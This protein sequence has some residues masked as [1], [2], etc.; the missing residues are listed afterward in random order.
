MTA[1]VWHKRPNEISPSEF[2][3][4]IMTPVTTCA[5]NQLQKNHATAQTGKHIWDALN[6]Q[7][8]VRNPPKDGGVYLCGLCHENFRHPPM[9]IPVRI[10]RDKD[11]APD[12]HYVVET[13]LPSNTDGYCCFECT[14]AAI[15]DLQSSTVEFVV[16]EAER[17][18]FALY[19]VM[20]QQSEELKPRQPIG[21][22]LRDDVLFAPELHRF[23]PNVGLF[24]IVPMGTAWHSVLR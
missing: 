4:W 11:T 12:Q 14:Y 19:S 23:V 3:N 22:P 9:G 20:H 17:N 8:Y 13:F 7:V 5:A 16:A 24:R 15:L 21:I 6:G 10:Y 18:L 1:Y 2:K